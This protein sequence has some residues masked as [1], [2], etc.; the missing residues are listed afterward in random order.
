MTE[1]E[2]DNLKEMLDE[3]QKI[4]KDRMR[5]RRKVRDMLAFLRRIAGEEEA[6]EK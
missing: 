6:D 5:R 4:H 1:A 2:S 3:Q